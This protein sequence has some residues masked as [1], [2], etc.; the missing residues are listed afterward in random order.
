LG[1]LFDLQ[2]KIANKM[3][4]NASKIEK[5]VLLIHGDA[6]IIALPESSSKIME[7]IHSSDKKLQVFHGADHWLY[8]SIIPKM[9]LKYTIEQKREVSSAVKNWLQNN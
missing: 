4:H 1:F 9:G 8:Q 5:P 2:N 7:K 6:D 3:T